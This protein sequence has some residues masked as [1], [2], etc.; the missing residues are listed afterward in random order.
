MLKLLSVIPVCA[1]FVLSS[2]PAKTLHYVADSNILNDTSL[3]ILYLPLKSIKS[4]YIDNTSLN[5]KW[6]TVILF[7]SKLQTR[8]CF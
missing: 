7:T 5:R 6:N 1:V 2:S 8:L 3:T 4:E